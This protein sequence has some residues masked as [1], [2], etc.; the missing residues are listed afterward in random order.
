MV[1]LHP[2]WGTSV[3]LSM[4]TSARQSPFFSKQAARLKSI[5]NIFL[6]GGF[7]T[8][9]LHIEILFWSHT[10]AKRGLNESVIYHTKKVLTW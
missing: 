2:G 5:T 4:S 9:Y 1:I 6:P 10:L 3:P 7:L 8:E